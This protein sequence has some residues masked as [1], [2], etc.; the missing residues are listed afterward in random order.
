MSGGADAKPD[1]EPTIHHLDDAG[2]YLQVCNFSNFQKI[3][4]NCITNNFL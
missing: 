3:L 4:L 1:V 2:N